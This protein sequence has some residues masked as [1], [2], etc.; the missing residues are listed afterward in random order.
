M[1]EERLLAYYDLRCAPL[2]FDFAV[3]L[4]GLVGYARIN[5]YKKITLCI[6]APFYRKSNPIELGYSRGYEDRKV[7]NVLID[8]AGLIPMIDDIILSRSGMLPQS[9]HSYPKN[10]DPTDP[11]LQRGSGISLMPCTP[12][13]IEKIYDGSGNP[14]IYKATDK[15]LE[16]IRLRFKKTKATITITLRNTEHNPYRNCSIDEFLLL[17]RSLKEAYPDKRIIVI[18][19]QDDLL[20][21]YKSSGYDWELCPEA[22]L[23]HELRLALYET[24]DLNISWNTGPAIFLLFSDSKYIVFGFWNEAS[25]V[26]SR[27][28]FDRK[29]PRFG[30]QLPWAIP[31]TQ[32]IDWTSSTETDGRHMF[33]TAK[34]ILDR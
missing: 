31:N 14:R 32:V 27:A 3:Y 29:G 10:Y 30:K 34:K 4:S 24:S 8:T 22:A 19:D 25:A 15:G 26:S 16:W 17:W 23:D 21:D 18:P 20:A 7:R 11:A 28:I 5:G 6:Y 9:S 12:I 13:D 33:A 1:P 2:S